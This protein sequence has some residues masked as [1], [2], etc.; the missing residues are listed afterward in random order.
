MSYVLF[1]KTQSMSDGRNY[2]A[3][4]FKEMTEAIKEEINLLENGY[5][6]EKVIETSIQEGDV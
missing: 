4:V 3:K 5:H 2:L 6:N 1:F